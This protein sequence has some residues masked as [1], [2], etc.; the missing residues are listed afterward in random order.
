MLEIKVL[1][2]LRGSGRI[3][4]IS[5]IHG[6]AERLRN[7]HRR[8]ATE[9]VPGDQLIY[10][11]NY[12]GHGSMVRETVDE[13]LLF[14]RAF[15]AR[16]GVEVDDIVYLRGAQE[17]MWQKLLQLQF[18][19]NPADVLRWMVGNG[20]ASTIA[21]YDGNLDEGYAST[22]DGILA[23]TRWTGQLRQNMR[24]RDGHTALM[25]ALKHAAFTDDD[26]L[27]FVHAGVNPALP[28]AAQGDSFWWG[29][30]ELDALTE[31]YSGFRLVIRGSDPRNRTIRATSFSLTLDGGC[32]F[33]GTLGVACF[34]PDG[35]ILG[36]LSP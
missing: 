16:L 23:L 36:T 3:W 26:G 13:L 34:G 4:A 32:G 18:A 20:V 2:T 31:S 27:L 24:A 8:L 28:L 22:R 1:A 35:Q 19:H 17:E 25:S 11:G 5:A 14:R 15:L 29:G 10:L 12:F 21:A 33:G 6:E 30:A 9:I 7:A